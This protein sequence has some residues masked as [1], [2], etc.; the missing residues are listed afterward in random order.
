MNNVLFHAI[1]LAYLLASLLFWLTMS[2]RQRWLVQSAGL[3]L[4][5]G[6]CF[7]TV[8]L[9]YSL[10]QQAFPWWE[11]A[12][13]AL[14]FLSWALV[15]AYLAT[16]W[17]YRIDALGAFLVP[18]AFLT[19]A[20]AGVPSPSS[21][22]FPAAVHYTWLSLHIVLALLGYAA[23][24]LT[25]CAG[26]MYLI[27]ARQLKSKRP[28]TWSQYLPSLTLLDELNARA[29]L[30]G[31]PLL[32]QGIITGSVWAKYTY[33]SYFQWSLTSLPLLV[34]W[35]MYAALLGGRRALGWQGIQAAR[36]TIGGFVVILASYFV[37]TL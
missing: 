7:Q 25:F 31:F 37:H 18:L 14:G 11:G 21:E 34:A 35:C 28:G 30:L 17:R 4:R 26:V 29:L 27:Q 19:A 1:L 16:V 12:T 36:A 32:T 15:A 3:L 5:G 20:A 13:S 10:Y 6:F 33:G 22:R 8:F 24:T 2:I 23:L 9:G